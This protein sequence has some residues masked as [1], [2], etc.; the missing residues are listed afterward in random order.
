MLRIHIENLLGEAMKNTNNWKKAPLADFIQFKNGKKRPDNT[1]I[2]PVYGGNGILGYS[3]LA[4]QENCVIIG[5]VG[6]YCGS[7]YYEPAQHWVS[8]NAISAVNKNNSDIIFDYYLLKYLDLNNRHIGTSQPLLTQEILNSIIF[9]WPTF[10]EQVI[11]GKILRAI[12]DKISNNLN[13]NHHLEQVA[14]AIFKS[15]FVDF[16]P[17]G[18]IMPDDWKKVELGD[19]ANITMGQSPNGESYN[20]DGIGTVFYQGR[21][22]FGSRFPTRRLFTTE[23]KRMAKKN[24][25]LMS[26]RAP[27]GDIN[28]AYETCCIGRG[29]AAIQSKY[30]FNSFILYTMYS[31]KQHLNMFNSEGTVFG[32]INKNDT[33]NLPVLMPS[34]KVINQFEKLIHPI[35][36]MIESN[37]LECCNLTTLRDTLLPRLMSGELRV[38][39]TEVGK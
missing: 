25:V 34:D 32:S 36:A 10:S 4:N 26:V 24:D 9:N 15:W 38:S 39:D 31:L 17:W 19:I 3:D 29:L 18:G 33:A 7:V 2:Y 16:E 1:G 13:T 30:N 28:I 8:D 14:Q 11:I 21:A 35:D 22:E 37:F 27:V 5:R 6:A 23:P 20:E 12:D